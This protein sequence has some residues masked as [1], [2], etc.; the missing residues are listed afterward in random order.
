MTLREAAQAV[1]DGL[2][3]IVEGCGNVKT[4]TGLH[5][6]AKDLA[7]LVRKDCHPLIADLRD[8]LEDDKKIHE[9]HERLWAISQE[10]ATDTQKALLAEFDRQPSQQVAGMTDDQIIELARKLGWNV[11][12]AETNKMLILF[13]R[14]IEDRIHA[15]IRT[16][17]SADH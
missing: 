13:A 16:D 6:D 8:A 14:D 12:H 5:K 10:Y 2:E 9:L 3:K 11:E 4:E 1:L 17:R 7:A 15:Q